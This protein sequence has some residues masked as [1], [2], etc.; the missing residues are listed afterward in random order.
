MT[1]EGVGREQAAGARYER[2]DLDPRSIALFGAG[3]AVV[4]L[5]VAGVITLFQWFAAREY[6]RRQPPRPPIRVTREGVEPR[7]QV[8]GP[9]ELRAMREA[10]DRELNTYGWIDR[11]AGI[12]RIP[13]DRAID[14]LA[15]KGLPA[16]QEDKGKK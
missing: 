16:R 11:D 14:I 15:Q 7:L 9:A 8:N 13:I 6:V 10:E 3:L 2:Q 1:E 5:I 12:V 4:L